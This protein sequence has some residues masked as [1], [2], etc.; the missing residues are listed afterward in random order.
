VDLVLNH[1]GV[2]IDA[3]VAPLLLICDVAIQGVSGRDR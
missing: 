1:F 3:G 2:R